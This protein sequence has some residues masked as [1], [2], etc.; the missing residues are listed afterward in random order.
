[1][2]DIS[3]T[4]TARDRQEWRMWLE[5]HHASESEVW[6]VY[7]KKD[8]GIP[9]VNYEESVQEALCFGWI[10]STIK[11]L[12][13]QRYLRRFT[14]RK[15]EDNWSETNKRRVRK[16]IHAGR[17]TQAGL[18][19]VSFP[20]DEPE[21]PVPSKEEPELPEALLAALKANPAAWRNF[22]RLPPSHQRRYIGWIL[23]AKQEETRLRRAALAAE[24]LE[25][26]LRLGMENPSEMLERAK[27]GA[28]G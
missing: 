26:D 15:N 6:L 17:M 12:D 1:M 25:Y 22:E 18:A 2:L 3:Q 11:S 21:K 5:Q 19:K 14:P 13:E 9:C 23:S 7:Y 4:T 24:L 8:S 28:Q 10:D 27:R 20:L 16:M